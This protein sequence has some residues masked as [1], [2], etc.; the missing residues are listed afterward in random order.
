MPSQS[1]YGLDIMTAL[2]HLRVEF[3]RNARAVFGGS[4]A[5]KTKS[6]KPMA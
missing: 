6:S 3:S 4:L 5:L 1:V 2:P